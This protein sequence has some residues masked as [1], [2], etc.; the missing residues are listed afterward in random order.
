MYHE[1]VTLKMHNNFRKEKSVRKNPLVRRK[2]RWKDNLPST[3][4]TTKSLSEKLGKY[5]GV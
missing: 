1:W 4:V 5:I 3:L 2:S